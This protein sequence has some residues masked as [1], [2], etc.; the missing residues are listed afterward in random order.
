MKKLIGIEAEFNITAD[1]ELAKG[2]G[3]GIKSGAISIN[4]IIKDTKPAIV[5]AIKKA[6]EKAL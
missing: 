4:D 5:E 1:E 6:V 2:I 3:Q